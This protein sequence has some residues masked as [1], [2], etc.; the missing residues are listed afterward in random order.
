MV[1]GLISDIHANLEA[2]EA[3]LA[4]LSGV[5]AYLCLG[6]IVGYGP[7]PSACLARVRALPG[8]VCIVGNHD[9]AAVGA[10]DLDWF[11]PYARHAVEWTAAQ[12]SP[13]ET[14][15]LRALPDKEEVAGTVLVHGSL[16]QPELMN[17]ITT[18]EDALECF[19]AFGGALCFIGHTHLTEYY[20]R[21]ETVRA[22]RRVGLFRGGRLE[23]QRD[24]RYL[25]NPGSVGQPRDGNP[26]ASFGIYDTTAR[27]VEIRRVAYD[28]PTV[29]KK[30]NE[31]GL[32][33]YLS[34][35]LR[36]GV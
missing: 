6:D 32:P 10:Y 4:E 5:E 28:L 7:D 14:D 31:A 19:D 15:Y 9:L 8:L 24:R 22:C 1:Y 27:T 20:H 29:Q 17:Y 18:P 16:P 11:N 13:E 30:M 23:L 35:R 33:R 25:I 2:L 26:R 3:A 34:E 12:L 21:A 36:R